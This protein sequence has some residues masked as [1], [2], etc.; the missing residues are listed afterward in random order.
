MKITGNRDM[1]IKETLEIN[2][3]QKI[4]YNK[5]LGEKKKP[6]LMK[7]WS[8]LRKPMYSLMWHSGIWKDLFN[9]QLEWMGDL[10]NK[11]VLDFGCY[12]GN[13][14]SIHMAENCKY[15]LGIDLSDVAIKKLK[16][17]IANKN[18]KNA[19]ARA[20]DILSPEFKENNFDII[21]AQGVLHHFKH[22]DVILYTLSDKL[23]PSGVVI[24]FDPMQTAITSKII[25]ALYHPHR[26]DK[27]WEFPFT[28]YTFKNIEKYFYINAVQG[29]MGYSKWCIPI[30]FFNYNLALNLTKYSHKKDLKE[31]TKI[32][33]GF[34]KCM[35]VSMCWTKKC[36]VNTD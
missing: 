10:K 22:M 28:K 1:K 24:T 16:E 23:S 6:L 14:L 21:Y 26:T 18:I 13:D 27:E 34:W 7:Y 36:G 9:K 2:E 8:I 5:S 20:I 4:F 3:E 35:H 25:R 30:A 33:Y 29:V 12:S 11:K 32:G 19:E 31:A 15:Y 17:K